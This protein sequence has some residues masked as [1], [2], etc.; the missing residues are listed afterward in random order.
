MAPDEDLPASERPGTVHRHKARR[1][2]TCA[3][4]PVPIQL[5]EH[6]MY[7]NTFDRGKWS[8]YVLCQKCERIRSCH[9][10]AELALDAELPY[11][12]G[13]LREEVRRMHKSVR[14]YQHEFRNAWEDSE[15]A[16]EK[17]A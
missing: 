16:E 11:S 4:C 6:Y 17:K 12:S 14:N 5:G 9:R 2:H 13:K 3:E 8:R 10:V 7:L 1:A 15:P